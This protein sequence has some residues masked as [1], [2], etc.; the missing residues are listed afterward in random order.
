MA[1]VGDAAEAG[2][3]RASVGPNNGDHGI[4]EVQATARAREKPLPMEGDQRE[5]TLLGRRS[6]PLPSYTGLVEPAEERK[7]GIACSGGGI[8][9]AA[10]SL[11]ALQVLQQERKLQEASYLAGVSGGS[12]I[13]AAFSMVRKTWSREDAEKAE[14]EAESK[15]RPAEY[16]P[17]GCV[18]SDPDV[19]SPRHPP[20]F[21]GSPEEQY[22]RNRSSY[23]APGAFGLMQFGYRIA[24]GILVNLMF[25]ALAV[26]SVAIPLG[27]IYGAIYPSLYQHVTHAHLCGPLAP[28]PQSGKALC[29]FAPL[30]VPLL[31]WAIP[32]GIVAIAPILG[33]FSIVDYRLKGSVQDAFQIWTLRALL[34][35]ILLG[36]FL[37][38]LP[39]LL[40]LWRELG[41]ASALPKQRPTGARDPTPATIAVGAGGTATLAGAILLEL[42]GQWSKAKVLVGEVSKA[43]ESLMR[44]GQK[45]RMW[46][47]YGIAAIMGPALTLLL[48]VEAMAILLNQHRHWN[49]WLICAAILAAFALIANFADM[50]SWSLHPFYRRRL[51]TAFALKRVAGRGLPPIA[52][53]DAGIA[54]ER[55]YHRPATLSQTAVVQE[56]GA[57]RWPT[58]LVCASANISDSSAT[59]PG[60]AVTSFTF[61]ATAVG[62][63]LVGAVKTD[64]LER[65]A[66]AKRNSLTLPAAVAMSGA[67]LSPSMGKETRWPLRF[68][69]ALANI[70]L[71]VWVP[72]PRKLDEFTGTGRHQ[73]GQH[74]RYPRPRSSYLLRELFG[75]NSIESTY[76]YVTDG[77]HYENLGLVELLRR[78]CSEVYVFDASNDDFTAIGDAVTLARSELEVELAVDYESLKPDATTGLSSADCVSAPITFRDV[79]SGGE[80]LQGQLYY[81]RLTLTASSPTDAKAYARKDPHFP[82]DPTTDQLYTDQRFEA[83]RSLGAH[84]ASSALALHAARRWA[85]PWAAS[86]I[87]R[88]AVRDAPAHP[89]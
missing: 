19:V 4:L 68:L 41:A 49:F 82:H 46:L 13:A 39:Q 66:K 28:G 6:P 21:P 30:P 80:T 59:P 52:S 35:G 60:R 10:F 26:V 72:N 33:M 31:A 11:G 29:H 23:M 1:T 86:G 24:L 78:G 15:D 69:M 77:G 50:T 71:G 27:L 88:S 40:G 87:V 44:L 32:A 79:D 37:V 57:D 7:I 9:S 64:E 25:V 34:F 18:D 3:G 38:A 47:A 45:T 62:G 42:R 17:P 2:A 36:F 75:R 58:L 54:V 73:H 61:S 74:R 76:L 20:F 55:L 56:D 43:R 65:R 85:A 81:A 22:L 84:A 16:P 70:R 89:S 14:R 63:P 8:R 5:Y 12:Y 53:E 48:A 83:Y 51:C 67:A